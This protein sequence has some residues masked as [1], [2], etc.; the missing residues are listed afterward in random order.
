MKLLNFGIK[1][2]HSKNLF[3]RILAEGCIKWIKR[4]ADQEEKALRKKN[5]KSLDEATQAMILENIQKAA[6]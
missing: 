5:L 2:R 1:Y 6:K 4:R 3:L